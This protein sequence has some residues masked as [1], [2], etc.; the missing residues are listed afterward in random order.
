MLAS[1][2]RNVA[3]GDT[4]TT[5]ELKHRTTQ[6]RKANFR[7]AYTVNFYQSLEFKTVN[8]DH[9]IMTIMPGAR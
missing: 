3:P 7:K 6:N 8:Q 2:A 1:L 4:G 5:R 9:G